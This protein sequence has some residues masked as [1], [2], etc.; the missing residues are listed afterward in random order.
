MKVLLIAFLLS[1]PLWADTYHFYFSSQE[2]KEAEG[3][4]GEDAEEESHADSPEKTDSDSPTAGADAALPQQIIIN[5]INTNNN[6]NRN[7][8]NAP[9][10]AQTPAESAEPQGIIDARTGERILENVEPPTKRVRVRVTAGIHAGDWGMGGVATA[11]ASFHL[12]RMLALD[13]F[14]AAVDPWVGHPWNDTKGVGGEV[15]FTPVRVPFNRNRDLME[16]SILVGQG[17]RF[18]DS[19]GGGRASIS[20]PERSAFILQI[21]GNLRTNV[22]SDHDF[23]LQAGALINI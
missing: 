23:A 7:D 6:E 22:N 2:K 19:Y 3:K 21:N 4:T 12:S 20:G 13:L 9:L 1:S 14:A 8:L 17:T 11:G 18:L 5:N 16:L 10:T 15:I